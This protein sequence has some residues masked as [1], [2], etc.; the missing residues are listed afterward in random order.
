MNLVLQCALAIKGAAEYEKPA[1]IYNLIKTALIFLVIVLMWVF[2]YKIMASLVHGILLFIL[3]FPVSS[4]VYEGFEYLLFKVLLKKDHEKEAS[5]NFP[6][7]IAAVASFICINIANDLMQALTLSFGFAFGTYLVFF[8]IGEIRRR[9]ELEA[10]PQFL[11]GKPLVLISMGMLSL[12]FSAGS[13]LL[14]RMIG[15]K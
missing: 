2:F 4:M 8:I 11:R 3:M 10:V 12:V 7:G 13:L 1:N 5:I 6:G 14:F 15:A 9:A